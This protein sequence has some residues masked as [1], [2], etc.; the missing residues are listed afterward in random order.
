[1]QMKNTVLQ[2]IKYILLIIFCLSNIFFA[3]FRPL[4]FDRLA[5]EKSKDREN[6]VRGCVFFYQKDNLRGFDYFM[7]DGD[8]FNKYSVEVK[9]FPEYKKLYNKKFSD[10]DKNKCFLSEY[11]VLTIPIINYKAIRL[12]DIEF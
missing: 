3:I 5:I 4:I 6:L 1:M 8:V 10:S 2:N 9:Q 7:I 11:I 12:Y